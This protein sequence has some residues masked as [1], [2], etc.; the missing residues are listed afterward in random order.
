MRLPTHHLKTV[1]WNYPQMGMVA[2]YLDVA[3]R[4]TTYDLLSI[5]RVDLDYVRQTLRR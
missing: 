5:W 3:P 2:T 4:Y 1:T